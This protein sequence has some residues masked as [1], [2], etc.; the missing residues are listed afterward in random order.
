MI[1][2]QLNP[3]THIADALDQ[4]A[5]LLEVQQGSP[6][7]IRAYKRAAQVVREEQ[8]SLVDIFETEG[9]KGL[10]QLAGIGKSIGSAV[11]EFLITGKIEVAER[12]EAKQE[13]KELLM[14][15]PG[16]GAS[17]AHKL[18]H[19][20]HIHSLEELEMAAH[21]G[22][23]EKLEGFGLRRIRAIQQH[24]DVMLRRA[25]RLRAE[26][27]K[28][29]GKIYPKEAIETPEVA[30]L[31]AADDAYRKKSQ[32]GMLRKIAPRRFNPEGKAWLPIMNTESEGW[33]FTVMYSNTARAHELGRTH[34]WVVIFYERQGAQHSYT[35]V[36]E[37]QG[38][39]AGKRVVRG[40]EDE[41]RLYYR[42]TLPVSTDVC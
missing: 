28:K 16:I 10:T 15:V 21:D 26:K 36:T 35:V 30:T 17:L 31:L 34:D 19:Q 6:F 12:M 23:L 24:L 7:R 14:M 42:V 4:I 20:L 41:C 37:W 1:S 29:R 3:N 2:T 27:R 38:V 32:E 33:L 22:R 8:R 5:I 39:L 25:G 11:E 13:P 18:S 40:R 9:R